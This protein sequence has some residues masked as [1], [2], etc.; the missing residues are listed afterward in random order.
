MTNIGLVI[1]CYRLLYQYRISPQCTWLNPKFTGVV[2]LTLTGKKLLLFQIYVIKLLVKATSLLIGLKNFKS[3]ISVDWLK[4]LRQ[5][6]WPLTLTHKP[7]GI[8]K[9]YAIWPRIN[10]KSFQL[11]LANAYRSKKNFHVKRVKMCI[12]TMN[13]YSTSCCHS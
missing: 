1:I 7:N 13:Q 5:I 6:S 10:Y 4:L 12:V 8:W 3:A 11:L 2:K 9:Y